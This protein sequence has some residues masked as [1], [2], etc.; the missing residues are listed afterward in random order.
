[1][2]DYSSIV[3]SSKVRLLRNLNGFMFPSMLAG[4]E[5]IKVLNKVADTVLKISSL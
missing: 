3:V 4:E 2:K 5:G 1:M